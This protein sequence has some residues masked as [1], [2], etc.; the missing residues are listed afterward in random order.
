MRDEPKQCTERTTLKSGFGG[1]GGG[2][3]GVGAAWI[4]G[5]GGGAAGIWGAWGHENKY[6]LK[7]GPAKKIW[8]VRGSLKLIILLSVVMRASVTV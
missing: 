8:S 5:W 4:L 7:G 6:D 3:G 1:G 2:G